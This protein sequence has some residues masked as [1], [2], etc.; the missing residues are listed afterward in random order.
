MHMTRKYR[1]RYISFV[2]SRRFHTPEILMH[3]HLLENR[4][5]KKVV[6]LL[7]RDMGQIASIANGSS[8]GGS[9]R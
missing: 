2:R 4:Y 9:G 6:L 7:D 3:V 5:R 8:D 1:V